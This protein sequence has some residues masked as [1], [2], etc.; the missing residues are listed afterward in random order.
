MPQLRFT[1]GFLRGGATAANQIEGA[2]GVDG[3]GASTADYAA[4]KPEVENG[5]DNFTFS[6]SAADFAAN[7]AGTDGGVH[8]KRWGIDFYHRYPEDIALFAEMGFTAL[9]VS[10]A[11]T[12]IFPT[13]LETEPNE[14][15][16]QF[17]DRLFDEMLDKG[18]TPVVTLSHFEMPVELVDRYNGWLS[19]EPIAHFVR[20][21]TTVLERYAHKVG[22]WMTFNELNMNLTDVYTGAG[23]L[24]ERTDRPLHEVAYQASHHQLVS[25]ALVVAEARRILPDGG[26]IGIMVN[27][28]VTYPRTPKPCEASVG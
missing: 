25:S 2:F 13:G 24:I 10:I 23:V 17:Y 11:W 15:G 14:A 12:R 6:V 19:R 7:R 3:K 18:I 8:P 21:A 27:R 5:A 16:L 4:F 9:R 26:R 28:I 20:F 1:D 22:Y